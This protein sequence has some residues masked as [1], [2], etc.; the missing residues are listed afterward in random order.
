MAPTSASLWAAA[1]RAFLALF[2]SVDGAQAWL[3]PGALLG[4][5]GGATADFNTAIIDS[6][7]PLYDS[8]GFITVEEFP[9]WVYQPSAT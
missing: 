2:G 1:R 8:V 3:A 9:I 6:G 7:K 4:V 5:S